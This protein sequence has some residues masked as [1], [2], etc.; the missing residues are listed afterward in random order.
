MY[1]MKKNDAISVRVSKEVKEKLQKEAKDK[2]MSLSQYF[3]AK[4]AGNYRESKYIV[5]SLIQD[6]KENEPECW[7]KARNAPVISQLEWFIPVLVSD[8]VKPSG[9]PSGFP[10]HML[11]LIAYMYKVMVDNADSVEEFMMG[12]MADSAIKAGNALA[13]NL[14]KFETS[15]KEIQKEIIKKIKALIAKFAFNYASMA[16]DG[17]SYES[18]KKSLDKIERQLL[19]NLKE[20]TD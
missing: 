18:I 6:A 9:Q 16:F 7:K 11:Y 12:E 20:E 2:G 17:E 19:D 3:E 15:E 1:D 13:D 14:N 8:F 10:V 5:Q 4:I